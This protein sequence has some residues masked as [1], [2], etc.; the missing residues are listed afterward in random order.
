LSYQSGGLIDV[1]KRA[2]RPVATCLLHSAS[3]GEPT[4]SFRSLTNHRGHAG[5]RQFV[6]S[7][8]AGCDARVDQLTCQP[9]EEGRELACLQLPN[10]GAGNANYMIVHV[11]AR[12]EAFHQWD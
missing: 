10:D 3:P 2:S 5:R 4:F 8:Y 11:E 6:C 1:D 12:L 7:K 9:Q